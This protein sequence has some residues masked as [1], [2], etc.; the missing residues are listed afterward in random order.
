MILEEYLRKAEIEFD[1]LCRNS[2]I[3]P[4]SITL[5]SKECGS[6]Y[7][8]VAI[9][10]FK[11]DGHQ[12]IADAYKRGCRNFI[13]SENRLPDQSVCNDSNI[14][15]V[16]N[17]RYTLGV[18]ARLIYDFPDKKM[19]VIGVTG[20]KGKTT[21]TSLLFH[22]M[23]NF[24]KTSYFTTIKYKAGNIYADSERTTM[25]ADKL[26]KLLSLS[27]ND[28]D[29]NCIIEVSSH[30]VTLNRI[31]NIQWN[32][33]IFTS[34]SR[35]HLD[36]YGTM[37]NYFEAKLDFFRAVNYSAKENKFVVI[38]L[39]DPKGQ[40]VADVI[41]NNVKIITVSAKNRDAVYFAES[42][43]QTD[44]GM[45]INFIKNGKRYS[46]DTPLKG[47]FNVINTLLAAAAASENNIPI[48]MINLS[49]FKVEGRFEIVV[50][51]NPY[52]VIVDY[53]HTPDSLEKILHECRRICRGRLI[54]LFGCT[55]DRDRD[56]RE[57]M[58]EIAV[59]NS[60]FVI[61]TNDDTYTEDE[62]L[63]AEMVLRGIIKSG[64]EENKNYTVLLDRKKAIE[65]ALL[66][67]EKD[68]LILLAGM[69]H[70]KVQILN[71]G[72]IE[73]ND[74]E[75]V[76]DLMKKFKKSDCRPV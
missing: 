28:G 27:L 39:D 55:G 67:A 37:E 11:S 53:A 30:A 4:A 64:G 6:S 47:E 31:E 46:I 38:N 76:L 33:G 62:N 68:D 34:F 65:A 35:D 13:V 2:D 23:N 70:E 5:N 1:T 18:L 74:R 60:D 71:S 15:I 75:T 66:K 69:G 21:V 9:K 17:T 29:D 3:E 52:T 50:S 19:N 49:G 12:Y 58:G 45:K 57:I 51:S 63:I 40:N 41:S 59:K 20:T 56:K 25:E 14:S 8:F 24:Y 73:H 42:Y 26:Q 10:G 32:G 7:I 72:K 54:C 48:E 43:E 44:A 61:L 22:I 36:L 16:K